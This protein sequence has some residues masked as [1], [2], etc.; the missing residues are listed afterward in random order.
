MNKNI[1]IVI[2]ALVFVG[3]LLTLSFGV[4]SVSQPKDDGVIITVVEEESTSSI[5]YKDKNPDT[6][7][8]FLYDGI[9]GNNI[10]SVDAISS[11]VE[12]YIKN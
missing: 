6:G 7:I 4:V 8:Y 5:T 3:L 2:G 9:Y 10:R 12:L 11:P 1:K